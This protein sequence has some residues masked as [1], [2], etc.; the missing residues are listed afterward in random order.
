MAIT[1]TERSQIVELTVL[2]FN[3]APGAE[4]LSQIV[5]VY[6]TSG[7]SLQTLA[8]ILAGTSVYASLNPNTQTAEAFADAFL[9]PLGLQNDSLA[10]DFIISKMNAGVS[11]GAIVY[12]AYAALNSVPATANNQYSAA[13]AILNNKV[14]VAEYY[15]VER[16]IAATDLASLQGALSGVTADPASVTSAKAAIDATIDFTIMAAASSV[17]EGS[18]IT[19]HVTNGAPNTEYVL[20]VDS[21]HASDV[22]SQLTMVTTDANGT[23]HATIAVVADRMTEG[24]E[25]LT[26]SVVGQA[27]VSTTVTVNDTSMDNTEIGRAHV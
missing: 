22:G 17:N 14:T 19:V 11:K 21:A 23:A 18:S 10:R 1:A 24:A 16:A 9:T 2:M 25:T 20:R 13:N 15:S 5:S 12:E 4:Y 26:I 6:E 27:S 7:R 8:G 3:A